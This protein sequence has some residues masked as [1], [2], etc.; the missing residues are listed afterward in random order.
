[1]SE[2]Q[3]LKRK[4]KPKRIELRSFSLPAYRLTARPNR[5]TAL[6]QTGFLTYNAPVNRK[7]RRVCVHRR[8]ATVWFSETIRVSHM[9]SLLCL[10]CSAEKILTEHAESGVLIR[11]SLLSSGWNALR[12][13]SIFLPATRAGAESTPEDASLGCFL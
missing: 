6:R 8:N 1:M 3:Y 12:R 7:G 9:C 2:P 4:E 10:G 5:L 11:S 13:I